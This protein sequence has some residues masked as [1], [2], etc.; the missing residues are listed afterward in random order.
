MADIIRHISSPGFP[1]ALFN[2]I[3]AVVDADAI[4]LVEERLNHPP[5]LIADSAIADIQR[6]R[7]IDSYFSGAYLLDPFSLSGSGDIEEGFYTLADIAPDNF[8]QSDYYL[9]YYRSA[10]LHDDCFFIASPKSDIRLSLSC[11]RRIDDPVFSE[12]DIEKLHIISP[13]ILAALSAYWHSQRAS[14]SATSNDMGAQIQRAFDTFGKDSLTDR[15]RQVTH[16]LLRGH[17]AKSAARIMAISP[18]TVQMHRKNIYSKL[19]LS[20]QSELFCH[21]IDT[22]SAANNQSH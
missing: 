4:M 15:E 16:L 1:S 12:T 18:D 22:L 2:A 5:R 10:Q 6:P 17:S 8:W 3:S 21:F 19:G 9:T 7:L 14:L 13:I 11:G 20:S